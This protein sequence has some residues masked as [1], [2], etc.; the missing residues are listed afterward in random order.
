MRFSVYFPL[1]KLFVLND[2]RCY[3][4]ILLRVSRFAVLNMGA[5]FGLMPSDG[6]MHV[7]HHRDSVYSSFGSYAAEPRTERPCRTGTITLSTWIMVR[8]ARRPF[9]F[10]ATTWAVRASLLTLVTRATPLAALRLT[11]LLGPR[12]WHSWCSSPG[13]F[14]SP[15]PVSLALAEFVSLSS[16]PFLANYRGFLAGSRLRRH[17]VPA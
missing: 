15:L 14:V 17:P 9:L 16:T 2:G 12:S 13:L 8:L 6:R 4:C 5:L 10:R 3:R 11:F 1:L 7:W